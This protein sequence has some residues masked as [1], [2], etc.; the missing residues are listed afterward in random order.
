MKIK[1]I[2]LFFLLLLGVSLAREAQAFYNPSTGRWLSRD[3]IQEEGASLL[4]TG[5]QSEELFPSAGVRIGETVSFNP[6]L[7][8]KNNA[9]SQVDFLGLC[10]ISKDGRGVTVVT[11]EP[12]EIVW[13][14]YHSHR[15]NPVFIPPWGKNGAAGDLGCYAAY[16]NRWT[17]RIHNFLIPGAPTALEDP[18]ISSIIPFGADFLQAEADMGNGTVQ[19]VNSWLAQK[20]CDPLVKV[21]VVDA[22]GFFGLWSPP[23]ITEYR[24]S[25][26]IISFSP[27]TGPRY[28]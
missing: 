7:F 6:Y 22:S 24:I 16:N 19:L 21:T 5:Q 8:V 15:R 13:W 26:P 12:N 25:K 9:L 11:V 14:L 23:I 10:E 17:A 18:W 28:H 3:P 4:R 2:F 1:Q 27:I 20:S